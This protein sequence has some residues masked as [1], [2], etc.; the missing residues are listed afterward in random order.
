MS[1][2]SWLC[3][4]LII[5]GILIFGKVA[6]A[7][8]LDVLHYSTTLEPD[9]AAKSVRGTVRSG[10]ISCKSCHSYRTILISGLLPV[11]PRKVRLIRKSPSDSIESGSLTTICESQSKFGTFRTSSTTSG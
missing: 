5:V 9:I 10:F 2:K 11:V 4:A 3:L 6:H 1:E 8:A 7:A